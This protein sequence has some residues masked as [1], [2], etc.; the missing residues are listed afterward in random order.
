MQASVYTH[1]YCT[2]R[3]VDLSIYVCPKHMYIFHPYTIPG[4]A[5]VD[6]NHE[7]SIG[8]QLEQTSF[9]DFS[10]PTKKKFN[11]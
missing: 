10:F 6:N 5:Y 11:K 2:R 9:H 7:W 3:L 4:M 8:R 1:A